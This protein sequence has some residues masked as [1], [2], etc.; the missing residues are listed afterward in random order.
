MS[1]AELQK[2]NYVAK[3]EEII[4]RVDDRDLR[5][6]ANEISYLQRLNLASIQSNGGDSYSQLVVYSITDEDGKHM[7]AEQ[8]QGLSP[9]HS[10]IFFLAAA[11]VNAQEEDKKK[12]NA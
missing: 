4:I 2:S 9:E 5:F 7:T 11:K 8:A 6:F 3:K 12:A 1:F 10:E